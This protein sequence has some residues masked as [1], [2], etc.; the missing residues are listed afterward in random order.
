MMQVFV[1][2]DYK[3]RMMESPF[4]YRRPSLNLFDNLPYAVEI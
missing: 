3:V 2:A 1:E 4:F